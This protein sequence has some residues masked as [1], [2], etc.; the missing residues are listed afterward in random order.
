M[1]VRA[2]GNGDGVRVRCFP[3][4]P[5]LLLGVGLALALT[6]GCAPTARTGPAYE[7]HAT[8]AAEAV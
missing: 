6:A 5:R 7:A 4:F 1:T 3:C 8:K 2:R